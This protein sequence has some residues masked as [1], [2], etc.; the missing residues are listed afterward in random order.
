M[1]MTVK[2][3][4]VKLANGDVLKGEL[5]M[6]VTGDKWKTF[7][8]IHGSGNS[9]RHSSIVVN[10]Q[11]VSHNF[12][13]I[14]QTMTDAG[15]AVFRYD[16]RE[17][18]DIDTIISDAREVVNAVSKMDEVKEILLY[19]WS[20]GVRVVAEVMDEVKA[21]GFILHAGLAEGWGAYFDYILKELTVE[22]FR[23]L[24]TDND[25]VLTLADFAG[26]M[27][28]GTSLTL[29][30]YVLLLDM[31]SDGRVQFKKELDP[32]N[33]GM[34]T[35]DK[36][37]ELA[38]GIVK[39]PTSLVRFAENA[40]KETW[41]GVLEKIKTID[42]PVLILHGLNDGWISPEGSVRLAM[43]CRDHADIKIFSG[44]GHS[45]EKIDSPLKDEGGVIE[46]EVLNEISK[47]LKT[48]IG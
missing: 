40:P 30:I 20:E 10:G 18:A 48:K 4:E 13:E 36:W 28:N 3:V 9:D 17:M 29:S 25:G 12:D 14:A 32:E 34:F 5:D 19:G 35:I 7:I 1:N 15:Y 26:C 46:P 24:D 47:W 31:L 33:K 22:K 45:L 8:L 44:L 16:K 43:S 27:P 2:E 23:E 41:N 39:D 37:I 42:V 6:P 21:G 11:V 38:D